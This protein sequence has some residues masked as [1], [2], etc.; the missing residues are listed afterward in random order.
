[1]AES[2]FVMA[3]HGVLLEY[4]LEALPDVNSKDNICESSPIKL[5]VEA[6]G[7]WNLSPPKAN[8]DG[9]QPPLSLGNPLMD[10]IPWNSNERV[11][12]RQARHPSGSSME[13]NNNKWLS[14]VEIVTHVG[15]HRRLWMGPQF[16]FKTLKPAKDGYVL[17]T[18][19][20]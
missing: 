15:P 4:T 20:R 1:M 6:F 18:N 17:I 9:L 7:Q 11:L 5:Q 12:S 8:F 3:S 16:C 14:Q 13:E 19:F 2:L 10:S